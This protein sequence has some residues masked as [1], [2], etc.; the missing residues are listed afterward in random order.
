MS[1]AGKRAGLRG[2][3]TGGARQTGSKPFESELID[4]RISKLTA[5]TAIKDGEEE[6]KFWSAVEQIG[7]R[8][9]LMASLRH[10]AAPPGTGR[11]SRPE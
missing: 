2:T 6:G 3:D 10:P 5:R 1:K 9:M 8:T 7:A 4:R 11:Q